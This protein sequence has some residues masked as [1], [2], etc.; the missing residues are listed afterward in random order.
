MV[1]G[2]GRSSNCL[3]WVCGF[4]RLRVEHLQEVLLFFAAEEWVKSGPS[5]WGGDQDCFFV[6]L[7]GTSRPELTTEMEAGVVVGGAAT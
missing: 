6:L 4:I 1:F 5:V 7:W 2:S 3:D